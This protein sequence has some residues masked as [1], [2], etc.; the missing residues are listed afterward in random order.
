MVN[1]R[2]FIAT[3]WGGFVYHIGA[4]GPHQ[5]LL[6]TSAQGIAAGINLYDPKS[7]TMYMTTDQH[8]TVIALRV[9]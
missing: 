3:S 5:Q 9:T 8:N 2:E 7:K 6:N 4:D 1:E